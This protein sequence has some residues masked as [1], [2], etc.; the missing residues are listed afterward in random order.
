MN[1]DDVAAGLYGLPPDEFVAARAAKAKEAK[2]EGEG[3]LATRIGRLRKPTAA[4][5]LANQLPRAHAADVAELIDVGEQMRRATAALDGGRLRELT[6]QRRDLIDSLLKHARQLAKNAG[7]PPSEQTLEAVGDT[8]L[9]AAADPAAAAELRA[10][11]L[12]RPLKH[13]GFGPIADVGESA[14]VISLSEIRS[15]R[16]QRE[17]DDHGHAEDDRADEDQDEQA[18]AEALAEA[19]DELREAEAAVAEADDRVDD[20]VD[21]LDPRRRRVAEVEDTVERLTAELADARDELDKARAAAKASQDELNHAR[22]EA[23]KAR[24][25][26]RDAKRRLAALDE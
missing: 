19:R 17:K 10:G 21:E 13:V 20:L 8:L 26:R 16:H 11:Q 14:E 22:A 25:R 5:W 15:A 4:A 1:F 23:E 18:R 9:A 7:Q 12:V 3:Q 24:Q 6:A 2:S